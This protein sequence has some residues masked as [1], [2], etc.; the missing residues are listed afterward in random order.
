MCIVERTIIGEID[1]SEEACQENKMPQPGLEPDSSV[2][3]LRDTI[4]P[5]GPLEVV[6]NLSSI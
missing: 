4:T 3:A 5:L 2:P 6:R 1:A